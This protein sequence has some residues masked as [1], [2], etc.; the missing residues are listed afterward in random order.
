MADNI[1]ER[2]IVVIVSHKAHL[3]HYEIISVR[4]CLSVLAGYRIQFVCPASLDVT[5]L[6]RTFGK[7]IEIRRVKDAWLSSWE[8]YN[9]F[10]MSRQFYRPY[11]DYEYILI[12]ET[13]A[14]V[15]RDDLEI[16]MNK[17]YSY[18]GAPWVEGY[19]RGRANSPLSGVGNGGF[20]LRRV[21]DHLRALS[22]LRFTKTF[23]EQY[24]SF[25][26]LNVKG[27]VRHAFLLLVEHLVY[28]NFHHSFK[29]LHYRLMR[30]PCNED[31][32]WGLLAGCCFEWFSVPSPEEA[33]GFAI[34]LQPERMVALNGGRIPMGAHAWW[35]YDL[36]FWRPIIR[37][38]GHAVDTLTQ[39]APIS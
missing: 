15:F 34:E 14:F 11:L 8:A 29:S 6:Y 21:P 4:Q 22:S 32:F 30:L 36:N 33:A 17:E 23:A 9:H 25:A 1:N 19:S 3:S 39:G 28:N 2:A 26:K 7:E 12:H 38:H 35:K 10:A 20:S 5:A 16:W 18:I 13:D 27:R 37:S 31:V 24:E